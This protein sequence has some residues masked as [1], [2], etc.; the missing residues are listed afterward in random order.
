MAP[1]TISAS[2]SDAAPADGA[3]AAAGQATGPEATAKAVGQAVDGLNGARPSLVLAFPDGALDAAEQTRQA[4][5]FSGGA[6]VAGMTASGAIGGEGPLDRGCS[7]LAFGGGVEASVGSGPA[8]RR[9]IR[10]QRAAP[11][12][13][14]P[15]PRL[16]GELTELR[17][18]PA[19]LLV[20]TRSGDQA[21]TVAGAYEVA[22][23]TRAARRRRRGRRPAGADRPRAGAHAT[24]SWRSRSA[25]REPIGVGMAHGCRRCGAR[26]SSPARRAA[27]CSSSTAAR[28]RRSTS[29]SSARAGDA[30]GDDDFERPRRRAP[31]RPARA[32]R[33]RAPA[34]RDRA[35]TT[36]AWPA[37][38]TS[39]PTPRCSSPRSRPRRSSLGARTRSATR[40]EP[41]GGAPP[42][43][44]LVFDC[45]GRKHVLGGRALE[46]EAAALLAAFGAS[47]PPL[48]GLYTRGEIGRV[49][50][51][52]GDRN[53]A[54]VVVAFA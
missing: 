42:R 4:D 14:R 16:L 2:T 17:H 12:P 5:A 31:A 52:K 40:C 39:P 50:G 49:R 23:G 45:A 7:A 38:R 24:R 44:A 15:S 34:P 11:P 53:H 10:G 30:V 54:V 18:R 28:P 51:A 36:A 8:S 43:A 9:A 3:L 35:P 37:R 26:P 48:A 1:S 20:D 22:G 19:R 29:R 25:R 21:D 47:P 6:S 32:A 33:R 13:P 41:L 27:R 46:A